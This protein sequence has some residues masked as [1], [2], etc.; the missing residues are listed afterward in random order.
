MKS[1]PIKLDSIDQVKSFVDTI[2]HYDGSFDLGCDKHT[3]DA[4]SIMGV[5]SLDLNKQLRL[6]VHNESSFEN[7]SQE[8][9]EFL[10]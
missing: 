3:V 7:I 9:T 8:L 4:K 10:V 1:L 5:L 6:N 2:S